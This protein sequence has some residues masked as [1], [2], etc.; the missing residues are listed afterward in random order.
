MSF[1]FG[2]Y[3]FFSYTVPGVLYI[4]VADRLLSFFHL[5]HLDVNQFTANFSSALIWVVAAF[6]D[7]DAMPFIAALLLR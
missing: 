5:P 4:L 2:L 3:D 1:T 6:F 7:T